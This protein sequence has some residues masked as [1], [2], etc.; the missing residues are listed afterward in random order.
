METQGSSRISRE[1]L[2]PL[3][4]KEMYSGMIKVG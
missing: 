2:M 1:D 3:G 4:D